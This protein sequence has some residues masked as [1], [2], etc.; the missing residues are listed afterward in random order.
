M[1]RRDVGAPVEDTPTPEELQERLGAVVATLDLWHL[2]DLVALAEAMARGEQ[3]KVS[4]GE[5]DKE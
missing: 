5:G 2:L 3:T 4:I 1:D